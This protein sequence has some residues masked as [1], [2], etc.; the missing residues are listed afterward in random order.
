MDDSGSEM[1]VVAVGFAA[2]I[3]MMM[4][5]TMMSQGEVGYYVVGAIWVSKHL[6]PLDKAKWLYLRPWCMI[7]Y[8]SLDRRV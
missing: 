7:R 4:M 2:D 6:S 3:R 1:I 5:M 8:K